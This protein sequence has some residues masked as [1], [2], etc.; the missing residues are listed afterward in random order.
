[1]ISKS[2]AQS[3]LNTFKEELDK[4]K[5]EAE[6]KKTGGDKVVEEFIKKE[7]ARRHWPHAET[8]DFHSL[9]DIGKA[10]ALQPMREAYVKVHSSDEGPKDKRFGDL[11]FADLKADPARLFVPTDFVQGENTFVYWRTADRP[12]ETQLFDQVKAQVEAAWNREK[13]RPL[14]EAEAE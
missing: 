9:Y 1:R 13:A 14:A 2:L 12:P 7:I 6:K 10:P 8:A 5:K 11:F 4:V 3:D